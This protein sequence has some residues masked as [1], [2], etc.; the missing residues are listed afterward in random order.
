MQEQTYFHQFLLYACVCLIYSNLFRRPLPKDHSHL[1]GYAKTLDNS[2]C[3]YHKHL[4]LDG[5][6]IDIYAFRYAFS[7]PFNKRTFIVQDLG[8]LVMHKYS[9]QAT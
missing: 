1:G 3:L 2:L 5:N 4:E 6:S 7:M 9:Y 8:R